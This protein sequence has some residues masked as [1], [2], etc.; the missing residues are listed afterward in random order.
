MS[1]GP[2]P[3]LCGIGIC[4]VVVFVGVDGG[5]RIGGHMS[6]G[7]VPGPCGIGICGVV[8]FV[9]VDG[10]GRTGGHMSEGPGPGL[11]LRGGGTG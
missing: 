11:V 2:F 5:G 10:R 7:P 9:G 8:A 1:E 4:G 6:E 3:G